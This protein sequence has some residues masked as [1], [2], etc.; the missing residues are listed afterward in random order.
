MDLAS[1]QSRRPVNSSSLM[2][3]DQENA[4]QNKLTVQGSS[5]KDE[6]VALSLASMPV[7]SITELLGDS[8]CIRYSVGATGEI[9]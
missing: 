1:Q 5:A 2:L 8:S 6:G 9:V 7:V 4:D 3:V